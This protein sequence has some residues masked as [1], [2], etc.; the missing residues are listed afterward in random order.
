MKHRVAALV[1]ACSLALTGALVAPAADATASAVTA[2]TSGGVGALPNVTVDELPPRSASRDALVTD[3]GQLTPPSKRSQVGDGALATV[4]DAILDDEPVPDEL[5][6]QVHVDGDRLRVEVAYSSEPAARAAIASAGGVNVSVVTSG[7]LVADVPLD[8]LADVEEADAVTAVALPGQSA[9][10]P[11]TIRV[12]PQTVGTKGG[13]VYT[14]T[15]VLRWHR[16]GLKGDGVRIGIVDYFNRA[17]WKDARAKGEIAG[18]SGTFCRSNGRKCD[19]FGMDDDT[20]LHGVAVAEAIRDIA[21]QAKIYIATVTTN[22]D[23]KKAITWF[24]DNG[25]R[26][27]TRSLGGFFDGPG[28]GKGSSAALVDY[29][30]SKGI[31]WFNSAGNAGAYTVNYNDGSKRL[32]GGYWRDTFRDTNGNGW[33]EFALTRYD[34]TKKLWTTS[35]SET[36]QVVCTPYFRLRWNDW[37]ADAPTDYDIY[38]IAGGK[39]QAPGYS[40]NFQNTKGDKPLELQDGSDWYFDCS[41][42]STISVG[43]YRDAEGNGSGDDI[44]EL[45]G[46]S[47]DILDAASSPYSAGSAFNDSK[48]PGIAV[49]GAVDPVGGTQAAYYS[50]QGPTN[51][52]RIKPELSAGSNFT[53]RAYTWGGQGGRF[54]GTSAATPVAAAAAALVVQRYPSKTPAE[55]IEYLRTHHTTDRGTAGIDSVYGSGELIMREIPVA[56]FIATPAPKISGSRAVGSTLK[57]VAPTWRPK[58]SFTYQWYRGGKPI[59]GATSSSY[60][61]TKSDAGKKIRVLATGKRGGFATTKKSSGY[62]TPIVNVFSA[63]P[64][65]KISGTAKVGRTLTASPGTWSPKPAKITYQWKADGKAI[66]GA[67]KK[68]YK[69]RSSV[70]GKRI[71]VTVKASKSGYKTT[72]KT[73]AKTAKAVR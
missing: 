69:V 45:Q 64:K 36:M 24:A 52:G 54:N 61:L 55:I 65:P 31:A 6:S 48:N 32:V 8:G 41:Y 22:A 53:S 15:R 18:A 43:I 63:A 49:V 66:K 34:P 14:K 72:T 4:V 30:V 44:L 7:V 51:D 28:T 40:P 35:Y 62:T 19:V 23:L 10:A 37:G 17:A 57:A 68:T 21:P 50:S 3:L 56:N 27:M 47:G 16:I 46:N 60:K 42:G 5:A 20:G 67:T 9:A 1:A 29:A 13:E 11:D 71:T 39:V 2:A 33:H 73:S 25:V 58:A 26:V 38:R 59:S 70:V 12:A